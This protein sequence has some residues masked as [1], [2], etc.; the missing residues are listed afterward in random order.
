MSKVFNGYYVRESDHMLFGIL[1]KAETRKE[2][3]QLYKKFFNEEM[4]Q[5]FGE[6][7]EDSYKMLPPT[8]FLYQ[9]KLENMGSGILEG[10][11]E[12]DFLNIFADGETRDSEDELWNEVMSGDYNVDCDWVEGE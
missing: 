7:C 9:D 4:I 2:G 12:S 1:V 11:I 3:Y 8:K 6:D 10:F 5:N